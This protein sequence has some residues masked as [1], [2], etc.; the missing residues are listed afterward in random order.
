MMF[1]G[2]VKRVVTLLL[3]VAL[4]LTL[5]APVEAARRARAS[6][7]SS[8]KPRVVRTRT[9][10]V[11]RQ[12]VKRTARVRRTSRRKPSSRSNTTTKQTV[13]PASHAVAP[14]SRAA[15]H[16][17]ASAAPRAMP[18]RKA[19]AGRTVPIPGPEPRDAPA[20]PPLSTPPTLV[21]AWAQPEVRSV[22]FDVAYYYHTGKSA[23]AL[24]EDLTASWAEKGVNLVYFYAYN[25]VYGARYYTRY[26][27]LPV[28]DYGRQDLLGHLLREA[29][30]RGIRVVAWLQGPQ[31]KQMWE[32]HPEW[33]QQTADGTD[34]RPDADAYP[35]CVRSP[36]VQVWW[37][38]LVADLLDRYPELD[39]VD[40]AEAQIDLWGDHSCH[41]ARCEVASLA[42]WRASRADGLTQFLLGTSR[43]VHSRGKE[44]HLT[45]TFTARPD[46][47]LMSPDDVRDATG[48]DL[49]AVL[50]SPDRPEV[51]QAELIWQ[52]WAA[53]YRNQT[54]FT[55][56]WTQDAVSQARRLV[57]GRARL[58]AHVELTDFG[59]GGLTGASITRTIASAVAGRPYGVDIYDAHQLDQVE[60]VTRYLQTAW[61]H[62]DS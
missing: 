7:H 46:G 1:K 24:A 48:F 44:F 36:E 58:I 3:A 61:L 31:S 34:Y 30:S 17:S 9:H 13:R 28:E 16:R 54:T 12:S 19:P 52:Q 37:A 33:R 42:E 15:S 26:A 43:L 57:S 23:R 18:L 38:G 11:S 27:D 39:G 6:R 50:A 22:R 25:R 8:R 40:V 53:L 60:G 14:V 32:A 21:E 56:S 20:P 2:R 5:W 49:R 29:H 41:C 55:A 59:C 47:T 35:L 10:R 4:L 62:A 45:S 51:I